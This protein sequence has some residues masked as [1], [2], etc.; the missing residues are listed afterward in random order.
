MARE[1]E[2]VVVWRYRVDPDQRAKFEKA[3]GAK[4]EWATFFSQS[5][6]YLGSELLKDDERVDEYLTIDRWKSEEAYSS[7][8]ADHESDYDKIDRRCEALTLSES[9]IGAFG[10]LP[11]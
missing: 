8:L 10:P 2:Y 5:P 3:C 1:P 4:G 6:A 11:K 7:F 9:R